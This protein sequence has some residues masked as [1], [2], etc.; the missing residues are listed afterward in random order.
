MTANR[1]AGLLLHVFGGDPAAVTAGVRV[2]LNARR[3]LR[4]DAVIELVVQGGAVRGLLA[5]SEPAA[6]LAPLD[7]DAGIT[8]L[9]CE[10]SMRSADLD[11]ARLRDGVETVPAAVGHL[12]RRQWD[13]WAY[14]RL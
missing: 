10:N 5:D 1:P 13:G 12:A 8:V 7:D 2:A 14:V 3:D 4:D 9:A 6:S 11:A